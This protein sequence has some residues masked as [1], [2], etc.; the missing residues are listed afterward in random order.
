MHKCELPYISV[1]YF[2]PNSSTC[3]Y[4]ESYDFLETFLYSDSKIF[5]ILICD[6]LKMIV[7]KKVVLN[8]LELE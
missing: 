5:G 4:N 8:H 7:D 6:V 1:D 2:P 3:D